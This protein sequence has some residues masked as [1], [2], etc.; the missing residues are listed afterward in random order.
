MVQ[1]TATEPVNR[2]R[3]LVEC[4]AVTADELL[5]CHERPPRGDIAGR[6]LVVTFAGAF[7]FQV[8]RECSWVDS[9]RLLFARGGESYVDR[10][11]VPGTGHNSV[12]LTPSDQAVDELWGRFEPGRIRPSSLRIQMLAQ[13][14]R[15]T[16]NSLAAQEIAIAILAEAIAESRPITPYDQRCVRRA[17]EAML[18]GEDGRVSL[19]ELA[20]TIGVTSVYLTQCFKRSEGMPL[21]RYQTTLRMAR[22]LERLP[23][24]DDITDLAL[25]LG[26]SSH[27]HFTAA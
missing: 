7:E 6:K 17:K 27:S 9:G 11:A 23:E 2:T 8:G 3:R 20:Q 26:F 25:D 14:L 19:E 13:L 18:N 1:I 12:I 4:G 16:S 10:H 24:A 22:A 5:A 21:Y 15:R